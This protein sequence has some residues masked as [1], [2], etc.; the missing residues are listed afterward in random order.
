MASSSSVPHDKIARRDELKEAF[1]KRMGK[2]ST[3][4]STTTQC[5]EDKPSDITM[6]DKAKDTDITMDDKD[7]IQTMTSSKRSSTRSNRGKGAGKL[8]KLRLKAAA[9]HA[10]QG[11][12]TWEPNEV[13]AR[14]NE[15]ARRALFFAAPPPPLTDQY[16]TQL[17]S[18]AKAEADKGP[19]AKGELLAS[20]MAK[21]DAS[22]YLSGQGA[23]FES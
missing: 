22:A 10:K 13:E 20:F 7:D 2:V 6:D 16:A 1:I 18:A 5:S 4:S 8:E 3:E 15:A 14:N 23:A 21:F 11:L 19:P 9:H 12:A 17:W